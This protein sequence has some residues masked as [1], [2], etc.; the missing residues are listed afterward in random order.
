[1]IDI[2]DTED[3][4][5]EAINK[6]ESLQKYPGWLLLLDIVNEN[7]ELLKGQLLN[8]MESETK[9]DIDRVRD[10]IKIF[11]SIIGTPKMMIKRLSDKDQEIPNFDPFLT[12]QELIEAR[13]W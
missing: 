6:F 9:E 3:K 8:G 10:K 11:E 5:K 7:L 13:G 4:K 1:M 12:K 2:F